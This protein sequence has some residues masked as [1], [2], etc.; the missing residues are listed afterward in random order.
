[1]D[2]FQGRLNGSVQHKLSLILSLVILGVAIVAGAFAFQNAFDEAHELQ[3]D[4][5][6]QIAQLM[7][8]QRLSPSRPRWRPAPSTRT[9]S[10]GCS[11]SASA[12]SPPPG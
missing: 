6:R 4:M 8:H 3:D 1:M 7:D 11:S 2:G 9:R 5:L 12:R 10:P